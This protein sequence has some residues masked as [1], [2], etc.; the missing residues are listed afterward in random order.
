M[1]RT[2]NTIRYPIPISEQNFNQEK[3][4]KNLH[5][6]NKNEY[7]KIRWFQSKRIGKDAAIEMAQY[8]PNKPTVIELKIHGASLLN[9][10]AYDL[11]N[12]LEKNKTIT[13]LKLFNSTINADGFYIIA[14]ALKTNTTLQK[15]KFS[16][17]DNREDVSIANYITE[18][19][20]LNKNLKEIYITDLNIDD[21]GIKVISEAIAINTTLS[22]INLSD[23]PYSHHSANFLGHALE[24]N[25]TITHI[26]LRDNFISIEGY[27]ILLDKLK[28]NIILKNIE[29]DKAS[30]E[31]YSSNEDENSNEI[32][33][34]YLMV[35]DSEI[36]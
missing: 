30:Q 1:N 7:S 14:Q 33:G 32:S 31:L 12:F 5:A 29:I 24:V 18:I 13:S 6:T 27:K 11:I 17:N 21:N 25:N 35:D 36:F 15:I 10:E 28:N 26:V 16:G 9:D 20:K 23:N 22:K 3:F 34:K 4:L 19:I 2:S 8:F